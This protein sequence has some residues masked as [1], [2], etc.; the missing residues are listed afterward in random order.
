M[1]QNGIY[2]AGIQAL[3]EAFT[4][5]KALK[6]LN[7]NDNTIGARGA[8]AIADVLPQLENLEHINFGDC[9]LR[10]KGVLF[11]ADA[12]KNSHLNMMEII[13][14]FNEIKKEGG[15]QLVAALANKNK[16]K[17]LVL[18]GNQF[19]QEGLKQLKNKLKVMGKNNNL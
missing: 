18:N 19:G 6:I 2:H 16:L 14:D 3:S 15:L 9:L 10:T 7:L 5:N 4:Y 17:V 8:K 1:P 11:L 13:L 12:V